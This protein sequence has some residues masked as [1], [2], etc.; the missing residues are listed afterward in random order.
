MKNIVCPRCEGD[1]VN[2]AT[3]KATGAT[4]F[5]CPECDALW[6]EIQAIDGSM[7]EDLTTFL[8]DSG[9]RPAWTEVDLVGPVPTA[10]KIE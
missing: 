2:K 4:V 7:F 1:F 5:V 10:E 9:L 8:S 3:L 6:R